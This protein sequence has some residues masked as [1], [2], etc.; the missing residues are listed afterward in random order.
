MTAAPCIAG[1]GLTPFGRQEGSDTLALMSRAAQ[2]ALDDAGLGR[3]DVDGLLTGY[4]TTHPHLM[5]ATVFAEFF[6]LQPVYA[7]GVQVG[8][9]TGL[10][11]VDLARRLVQAGAAER[12]LVVAGENRLT[13]QTRDQTIQTL[14]QVGEPVHEVPNGASVPAYY[15]LLA[16]RYLA[17]T[18]CGE[19]DL[20]ELSVLMRRNAGRYPGAHLTRP[21][22]VADVMASKPIATP[23]KQLDCCPISDGAAAVVVARRG[24]IPA[25]HSGALITGGGQAH[26]HQHLSAAPEPVAVGATR[27]AGRA[28]GEAGRRI[29]DM[30]L[31]GIYDSFTVTLAELLEATGVS[32]AG[33]A[34]ADAR[35]GR[36]DLDGELPL[37]PHGGLMSYGHAG[38]AGGMS[39][40]VETVRQLTGASPVPAGRGPGVAL[41]HADGGVMSSH[42]SLILE[43][44]S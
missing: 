1:V 7:H 41:V 21:I 40:L 11:M 29:G 17:V 13:G 43:A 23:L 35:D 6:G 9:A 20:A 24:A 31:L 27:A 37:N 12:I 38:V 32:K 42:V 39:H 30:E 25:A 19:R 34:P 28:L 33:R 36:F 44:A 10:A 26:T 16:S 5:L 8:G 22:G 2:L 4:S 15:A 14:A 3:A 18:G